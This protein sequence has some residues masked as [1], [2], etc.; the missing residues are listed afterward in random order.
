MFPPH[1]LHLF[2]FL[3]QINHTLLLCHHLPLKT[4]LLSNLFT[5]SMKLTSNKTSWTDSCYLEYCE[6][7]LNSER[8]NTGHVWLRSAYTTIIKCSHINSFIGTLFLF[9]LKI[10]HD[11]ER[12]EEVSIVKVCRRKET[13]KE[14]VGRNLS[15]C[16][17]D[18]V[19]KK[20]C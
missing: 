3:M 17:S 6:N 5:A 18:F 11:C 1:Y 2:C 7:Q 16:T 20:V 13:T 4:N 15:P 12:T 14:G 10:I 19:D 8:D 9:V